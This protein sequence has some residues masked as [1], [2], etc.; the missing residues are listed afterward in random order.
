MKSTRRE[1]SVRRAPCARFRKL[2][3][4]V[5]G[6]AEVLQQK[7]DTAFDSKSGTHKAVKAGFWPWLEPFFYRTRKV[8]GQLLDQVLLLDRLGP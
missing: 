7:P 6:D 1:G 4:D 8:A 5:V 3:K 2:A